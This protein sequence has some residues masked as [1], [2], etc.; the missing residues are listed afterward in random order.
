MMSRQVALAFLI[1]FISLRSVAQQFRLQGSASQTGP[2]T[3]QMTP[4]VGNQAGMITSYY[5]LDLTMDHYLAFQLYFGSKDVNGADGLAFM[6]SNNCNPTLTP[7]QGLGVANTPNSLVVDFDTWDNG[8]AYNDIPDDHCGIYADGNFSVAGNIMDGT[9]TPVCMLPACGNVETGQWYDVEISWTYISASSQRIEI[10]LNGNL[11]CTSTQNHIAN[12]FNNNSIVF[13]S[14]AAS[15]GGSSNLQQFRLYNSNSSIT[16]CEGDN[17]TLYAPE[18]G[19]NY[20]WSGSSSTSNSANY[21]ATSNV[22]ITCNYTS[23]CGMNETVS[24]NIVVIHLTA[25]A[26]TSNSPICA[27][28]DAIF[29]LAGSA[30]NDV[31]YS[32]NGGPPLTATLD[33]SGSATITIPGVTTDQDILVSSISDGT[34]TRSVSLRD[35]VFVSQALSPPQLANNGPVCYGSTGVFTLQG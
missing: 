20:V 12:R 3:Y 29:Y 17:F 2:L 34:C 9:S 22:T 30:G 31:T 35:T 15:T 28:G 18:L 21:T 16:H 1:L 5:P 6:L 23:Y 32:I 8:V 27:G 19:T 4:D 13:W 25:P 10:W 26:I 24:F 33:A 14:V 7:G 11:L